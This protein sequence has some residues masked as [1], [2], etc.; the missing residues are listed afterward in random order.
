MVLD[1]TVKDVLK[2]LSTKKKKKFI[3][4]CHIIECDMHYN[5][6]EIHKGSLEN[7]HTQIHR[8]PLLRSKLHFLVHGTISSLVNAWQ[9]YFCTYVC[10]FSNVKSTL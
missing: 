9:I 10:I 3:Y 8:S 7:T 2:S 6:L 1:A 5:T 4:K